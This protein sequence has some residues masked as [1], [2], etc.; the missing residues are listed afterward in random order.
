MVMGRDLTWSEK[1]HDTI[2]NT[3]DVLQNYIFESYT[4]LLTNI[5]SMNS[6]KKKEKKQDVCRTVCIGK[7]KK[8]NIK[9]SLVGIQK[10]TSS[11]FGS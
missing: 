3:Y 1:T 6:I 2:Y 11:L 4:I 10:S 9:Q 5:T 7:V 8:I